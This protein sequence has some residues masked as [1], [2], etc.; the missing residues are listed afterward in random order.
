[1]IFIFIKVSIVIAPI[2]RT[3]EYVHKIIKGLLRF[4]KSFMKAS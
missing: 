1:M 2:K 3:Y 4:D